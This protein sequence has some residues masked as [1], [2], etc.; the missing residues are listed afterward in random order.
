[1]PLD[2]SIFQSALK[3][4]EEAD[5]ELF[6]SLSGSAGAL[7]FALVPRPCL[8]LCSSDDSAAEFY[9]DVVFWSDFLG[10]GR[11]LLLSSS[12][13]EGRM[14]NLSILY[15]EKPEKIIASA[16]A[17]SAPLWG[18]D[19][20]PKI[21][22][23]QKCS[24]GRD[25][26]VELLYRQGYHTVPVVS[27][28]GEM[29][30]R[31]GILDV[32]PPD[33]ENPVRIEFFGDEVES[34]RYFDI[35]AQTSIREISEIS[36]CPAAGPEAGQDLIDLLSDW[37]ML[38][39]E[40]D[41]L[42]RHF[43]D[44]M[45]RGPV[46]RAAGMTSLPLSGTGVDCSVR[47]LG[48]LGLLQG[49]RKDLDEFPPRVG[50]LLNQ[51]RIMMVC[52]SE[53]QWKRL[54]ELLSGQ[55]IESTLLTKG[56]DL[57]DGINPVMTIGQLSSGFSCSDVIILT[58]QDIFGRRPAYRP[59][60]KSRVSGLISSIED[61]KKGDYL[62]HS[63][64]GIGRF[65]GIQK[66]KIE[67]YEGDLLVIEY[68]G[69]DKLFVPIERINVIQKYH[70]PESVR[71]VIDRLGGKSWQR[72]K[73]KVEK[74]IREMAERLL[75]IY[76]KRT[77][78]QGTAFSEETE[79][80]RE[81]ESFFTYEETPDQISS[82]QEIRRDMER[83]VPM[84]RLLCGDVGYG[85]TEVVMRAC[86]KA[87]YDAMQVAVLVPTT[88]LAEQH[89]E[90]FVHRFS[91]FPVR[92]DYLSRFK[93][94]A[95]Q[96]QTL[97]SLEAGQIDIII[98]THR[99]LGSDVRFHNLGLLVIDEEHKFGVTHK[100]KI[101]AMRAGVDVLSLSATPIPRTLH[102]A[103]SG[104]RGMNTIETPPEDRL[105]VKSV[106][107]RFSPSIIKEAVEYEIERH[108]QVFYV[109]NRIQDIYEVA[110]FIQNLVPYS[111]IGVAHGQMQEKE[112][113]QVMKRF[114]QREINILVSTAIIGAGLDIPT[115]NTIIIDRA[116]RFGLADLYQL[117]G[118][119]GRSNVKAYAYFLIPGE[120]I[121]TG[122]ARKK[123]EA[124]Q[125][126]GYLGAGFRLALRDLEIR[127]AGNLL[128]AEQSGHIRA[129]GFDMYMEMLEATVA[130]LRG[131]E[132]AP[133]IEPVIDLKVTALIPEEYIDDPDLR[134]SIYRKIASAKDI[135]ALQGI[136]EELKD[137]FGEP[138]DET[139][140]LS[141][142][143]ELKVMARA[144][145]ISKLQNVAGRVRLLFA[146]ETPVSSD[147]I[148]ALHNTRQGYLRFLPEGGVELD[149]RGQAWPFVCQEL[150]KVFDELQG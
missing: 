85:K 95:E 132:A 124:I 54:R 105:A 149:L 136:R 49:E 103:L 108:G 90:T 20:Y 86:F 74:K 106:V 78:A 29:S 146:P 107:A 99:L 89:V 138:P 18:W 16:Q 19:D 27:G 122:D 127:G 28:A 87:V 94:R 43:P 109:H 56:S 52:A 67:G 58:E 88:I 131:G 98:G 125:E 113:E 6:T 123:L 104:I 128:G 12:G 53:G 73:Q 9:S 41:D 46:E 120:D 145:F 143:M 142:V 137:R 150:Q 141:E 82:I 75:K 126:L 83:P 65:L 77:T 35:D 93:S 80:H 139:I 134:L 23:S 133:A 47:G 64:H 63:E 17:A 118:R 135:A 84:D 147:R 3:S 76:A 72:T 38:L 2:L 61:F 59:I 48:G 33:G 1:M 13:D 96:Q 7:F 57:A 81:F 91:G 51:Y 8:L 144:L 62:V 31:G 37:R 117:R 21:R 42:K 24:A 69:G 130:E 4:F 34:L 114:F 39:H 110:A 112:L 22:L 26:T 121:M 97:K 11:P 14:K 115:A 25:G 15:R 148:F 116:D 140:R 55:G 100:E 129:V 30:I 101:K 68:Y 50:E 71:P 5:T 44:L 111:Q 79:L 102:M 32:F 92:I 70:A 40:P 10:K 119:V 66:E 45:T 36:I 60:R